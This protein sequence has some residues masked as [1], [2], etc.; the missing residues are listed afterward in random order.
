MLVLP[1]ESHNS[2][3]MPVCPGAGSQ[4]I[5]YVNKGEWKGPSGWSLLEGNYPSYRL[6]FPGFIAIR[7][8][9]NWSL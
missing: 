8:T 9:F 6:V 3:L 1:T 2:V 5:L 4:Y 7:I